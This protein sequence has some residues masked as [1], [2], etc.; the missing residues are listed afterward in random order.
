MMMPKRPA[1]DGMPMI[2]QIAAEIAKAD[3]ADIRDDPTRY[4]RL[5]LAALEPLLNPS[6]AM[7]D[8]AHAAASFDDL[9]AINSRRDFKKAVK[10]MIQAAMKEG[11]GVAN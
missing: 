7:I 2:D 11:A 6:D 10:A 9:W 8:A 3:G 4:R 1:G 5:A